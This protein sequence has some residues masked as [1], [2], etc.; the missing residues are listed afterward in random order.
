MANCPMW[1]AASSDIV[2]VNASDPNQAVNRMT[3]NGSY[4]ETGKAYQY[5]YDPDQRK[6]FNTT[7]NS[8]SA[9]EIGGALKTTYNRNLVNKSIYSGAL[10]TTALNT[11]VDASRCTW[12]TNWL[13]GWDYEN[14]IDQ[15]YYW[16]SGEHQWEKQW[17]VKINGVVPTLED[18]IMVK[19]TCPSGRTDCTPGSKV[20]LNYNGPGQLWGIPNRCVSADDYTV[21]VNCN[22]NS[23]NKQ[24]LNK[25][26][27][28]TSPVN[29]DKTTDKVTKVSDASKEYWILP[30]GSGEWYNKKGAGTAADCSVT[31]P[32]GTS[33][34]INVDTYYKPAMT[35]IGSPPLDFRTTPVSIQN[36][37]KLR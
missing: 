23:V 28:T 22:D 26:N 3:P 25:F 20:V 34:P 16:R 21:S 7:V 10:V 4:Y 18:P 14:S 35:D 12:N 32:T 29:A 6:L 11:V 1:N 31:L 17:T 15:Y 24:W 8:A 27:L 13:C 2:S 5:N 30:Q 19:Y 9:I 36:G 33:Q 37:V